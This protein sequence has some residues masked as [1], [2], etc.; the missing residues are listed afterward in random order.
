[1]KTKLA[2][3]SLLGLATAACASQTPPPAEM[4]ASQPA[5]SEHGEHTMPDGSNME[6]HK[7]GESGTHTMP[8]GT[9]MR[10]HSHG[11]SSGDEE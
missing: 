10:G 3:L 9:V 6:G 2:F 11:G 8:D 4:P 7:H 1:M 5:G